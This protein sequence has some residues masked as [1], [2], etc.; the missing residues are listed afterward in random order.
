MYKIIECLVD[1]IDNDQKNDQCSVPK[2]FLLR[3][4]PMQI[5]MLM[6]V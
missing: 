5:Y 3:V 2:I 1:R 4:S 6:G